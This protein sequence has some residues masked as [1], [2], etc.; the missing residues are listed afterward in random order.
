M[1]IPEWIFGLDNPDNGGKMF[2]E[3]PYKSGRCI[4][5]PSRY[6]HRGLPT[7]EIEP[8]IS[9]GYVFSGVTTFFARSSEILSCQYLKMNKQK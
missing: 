9:I 2:K 8:R 6:I 7:I 1:V 3:V 4:V 5:F